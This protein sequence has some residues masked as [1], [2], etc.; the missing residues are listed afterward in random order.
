MKR[1]SI[2]LIWLLLAISQLLSAPPVELHRDIASIIQTGYV[3]GGIIGISIL[4]LRDG[5]I[6]YQQNETKSFIPAS[7][8]KLVTTMLALHNLSSNYQFTTRLFTDGRVNEIND[9]VLQG[10]LIL[11]GGGDPLLEPA[12]LL[13][14]ATRLA[15]GNALPGIPAIKV[16]KGKI[17]TDETFFPCAGPLLGKGWEKEDLPWYYA[18]PANAL[19]CSRNALTITAE[20]TDD[21]KPA[22]LTITPYSCLFSIVHLVNTRANETTGS[23][24]VTVRGKEVI[25]SGRVAPGVKLTER[26][27]I[28]DPARFTLEQFRFAL[29]KA[30]ISVDD[31]DLTAL[32]TDYAERRE[33]LAE[34]TSTRLSNILIAMLK[35]SD[36]MIAEQLYWT[37][38]REFPDL[39][40]DDLLTFGM[41]NWHAVEGSMH[42]ADGS[43]L[44]RL[45]SITPQAMA[46]LLVALYHSEDFPIVWQALPVAGIDGTLR[47]RMTNSLAADN[48]RAKTGTMSGVCCL[49]GYLF[50]RQREPLVMVMFANGYRGGAGDARNVQD[51]IATYLSAI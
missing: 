29:Q 40:I 26:I 37:L 43:G 5:V 22:V 39:Q 21:G 25:V 34:T 42:M 28:P 2:V 13:T 11:Q 41:K 32:T 20:G 36:N 9:G 27:S 50:T 10:N 3:D 38:Q 12:D 46:G 35:N 48:M 18:A 23:I 33:L 4:S 45:N 31:E 51:K 30:G 15:N 7:T 49:A 47:K 8:N 14:L 19:S 6:W 24:D 44:S 16:V 1:F 17:L